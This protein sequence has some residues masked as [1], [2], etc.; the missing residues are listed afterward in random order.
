[1]EESHRKPG[2]PN[3]GKTG[4]RPPRTDHAYVVRGIDFAIVLREWKEKYDLIYGISDE[5]DYG[6]DIITGAVKWLSDETGVNVR[7]I[8]G[9]M[10][11]EFEYVSAL[12]VDQLLRA[13]DRP[14]LLTPGG[15]L[16]EIPNPKWS[17]EDWQRYMEKRGCY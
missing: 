4:N 17:K 7:R 15:V 1:M 12:Q 2:N 9:L 13:M 10:R 3:F 16:D 11:A 14:Y 5:T 6:R 8:N